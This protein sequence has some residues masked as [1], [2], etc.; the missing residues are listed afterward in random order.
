M[1]IHAAVAGRHT[2]HGQL[3]P[4]EVYLEEG[5]PLVG[6]PAEPVCTRQRK[7]LAWPRAGLSLAPMVACTGR[8]SCLGPRA[9]S[10][11]V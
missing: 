5:L 2:R 1:R 6:G 8:L 7:R 3:L 4:L 10:W 9:C 11:C